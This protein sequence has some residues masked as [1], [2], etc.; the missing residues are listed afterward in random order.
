MKRNY[1]YILMLA[2]TLSSCSKSFLD[3]PSLNNPTEDTYYTTAAQVEAATGF[4]YNQPW[5]NYLDKAYHCIGEIYSGNMI[6]SAG[7]PNYGNNSYVYMTVSPNDG[8][9]LNAWTA[10]YQVAG[11]ATVL[12]NTL[13]QKGSAPYLQQGEAECEFIRG[14][15]Y[16]YIGR[17]YGAAPIVSDPVALA[18]SGNYNVPRYVQSDVLKFALTD[19]LN[20]YAALPSTPYEPGRVTK[21]SAAGMA[22]KLYLYIGNYDSA[23]Y[24]SNVVIQSGQYSLFPDYAGMFTQIADNNNVESLFALQWVGSGG[25]SYANAIQ[26]YTAPSTLLKPDFNTGYSSALPTIDLLNSYV[27]GDS[28]KN[29]S[30]MLQGYANPAWKNANFPNGFTYDTTGAIPDPNGVLTILNPTRTNA[31]KYTAGPANVIGTTNTQGGN[32][33]CVYVLRYADVLLINAESILA[34]NGSTTDPQALSD[35]NLVHERAGLPPVTSITKAMI[36][37]ER[38][39]EFAFESD[40]WY[41]IQ[42]QGFTAASAILN[43]QE[44]GSYNG[45]GT[46]NHQGV[47]FTQASQLFMPIPADE[48]LAD[49]ALSSAPVPYY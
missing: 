38:R 12:L 47:T 30:I 3:R 46:I 42:R 49:P 8:Q 34:A 18:S 7:D 21:W 4:L 37:A 2:G 29:W 40:Y 26:A 27:I 28:R 1:L 41:D 19:F 32:S 45:D 22:A 39:A 10:F 48:V 16:F 36:F 43:A 11:N 25:Y 15:A 14:A 33:L 5:Y 24:W 6:S 23:A 17:V 44:R 20:A 13:K 31:L 9:V 35:F